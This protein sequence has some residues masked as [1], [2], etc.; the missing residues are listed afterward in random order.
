MSE[1]TS[2]VVQYGALGLLALVL[3]FIGKF[4]ASA[5]VAAGKYAREAVD[6]L[7]TTMRDV[8]D[9]LHQVNGSSERIE[10]QLEEVAKDVH[11]LHRE[12]FKV[13]PGPNRDP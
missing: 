10:T 7:R 5:C 12:T 6:D 8:R 3:V 9:S 13:K 1:A 2:T 4:A 11:D